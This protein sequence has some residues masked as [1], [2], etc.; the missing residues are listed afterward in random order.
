MQ[1]RSLAT[2]A[3]LAVL[4]AG[5]LTAAAVTTTA[6]TVASPAHSSAITKAQLLDANAYA[7]GSPIGHGPPALVWCPYII[8]DDSGNPYTVSALETYP[9]PQQ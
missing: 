9:C 8:L 2:M 6:S 7:D 5:I 4:P 3:A 1:R